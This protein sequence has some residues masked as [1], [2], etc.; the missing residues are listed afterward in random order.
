MLFIYKKKKLKSVANKFKMTRIWSLFGTS[1]SNIFLDPDS[2][3][4]KM[5]YDRIHN[6]RMYVT[7]AALFIVKMVLFCKNKNQCCGAEY[8]LTAPATLHLKFRLLKKP[9]SLIFCMFPPVYILVILSVS[10]ILTFPHSRLVHCLNCR[11]LHSP[12]LLLGA[13]QYWVF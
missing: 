9:S 6:S 7:K 2:A 3:K 8:L 11:I 10:F 12:V 13:N 5:R 4:K 1:I